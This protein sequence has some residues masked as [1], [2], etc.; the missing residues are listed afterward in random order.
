MVI[1]REYNFVNLVELTKM[2]TPLVGIIVGIISLCVR[3]GS[4]T[5]IYLNGK[6]E[7]T[8]DFGS[9]AIDSNICHDDW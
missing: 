5:K 1:K 9:G 8:T 4:D 3:E 7:N 2:Y 6:L